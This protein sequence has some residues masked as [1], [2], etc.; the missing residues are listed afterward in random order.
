MPTVTWRHTYN[1]R[2]V[3]GGTAYNLPTPLMRS[4]EVYTKR[5]RKTYVPLR[6]GCTITGVRKG[7]LTIGFD[8][9]IARGSKEEALHEKARLLQYLYESSQSFT[10]YRYYDAT[11]G[12]AIWFE[13]CICERLS[14]KHTNN[15]PGT[16][17]LQ[18][19]LDVIVPS[20]TE[21]RRN[22]I[23]SGTP[24]FRIYRDL[25]GIDPQDPTQYDPA[26]SGG[27]TIEYPVEEQTD[28]SPETV[29]RLYGPLLVKLNA[30][31]AFLIQN[32]AGQYILR[33]NDD[34]TVEI[35]GFVDIVD[36]ITYP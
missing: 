28:E 26:P 35:A 3:I 9:I 23:G 25:T 14:F 12:N 18:Y 31:G 10:F 27:V 19:S 34:G 7:E 6:D 32:S 20:G 2:I 30:G 5:M 33:A 21:K 24:E 1:P 13:N 15:D 17:R 4:D 29:S 16:G 8:G 22:I 36:S 11:T